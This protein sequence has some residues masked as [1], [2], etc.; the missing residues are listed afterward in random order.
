MLIKDVMAQI[1]ELASTAPEPK[2]V[3]WLVMGEEHSP[4]YC[5]DCA[6]EIINWLRDGGERPSFSSHDYYPTFADRDKDNNYYSMAPGGY[7]AE[8]CEHCEHCGLQLSVSLREHGISSELDHFEDYGL[9]DA[10]DWR[11]FQDVCEGIDYVEK[12]WFPGAMAQRDVERSRELHK[13]TI[14]LAAKFLPPPQKSDCH[15][16]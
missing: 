4:Y 3:C 14:A 10:D 16:I 5:P 13:R 8:G 1:I 2:N 7:E 15:Q 6:Q 11:H 9:K 12:D